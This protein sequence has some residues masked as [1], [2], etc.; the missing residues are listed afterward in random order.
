MS[1][2]ELYTAT[3]YAASIGD[4]DKVGYGISKGMSDLHGIALFAARH[5]HRDIVV[6]MIERGCNDTL[7]IGLHAIHGGYYRL[8]MDLFL[9]SPIESIAIFSVFAY[10]FASIIS[11][12]SG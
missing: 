5:G 7:S 8:G 2:D 11:V 12:I 6:D 3:L 1:Y 9:L 4:I 10:L